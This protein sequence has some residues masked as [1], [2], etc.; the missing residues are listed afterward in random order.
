MGYSVGIP[1]HG[2][3]SDVRSYYTNVVYQ[4]NDG[5]LESEEDE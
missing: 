3:E 2:H 1:G 5:L 4:N